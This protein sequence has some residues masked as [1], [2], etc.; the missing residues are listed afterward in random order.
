MIGGGLCWWTSVVGGGNGGG[1]CCGGGCVVRR[2]SAGRSSV[3]TGIALAFS[4][5]ADTPGSGARLLHIVS[6]RTTW[7]R[8]A[9]T[10]SHR[11][12]RP[13]GVNCTL[14]AARGDTPVGVDARPLALAHLLGQRGVVR[15]AAHRTAEQIIE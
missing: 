8:V 15:R 5:L 4:G 7:R 2:G 13:P 12:H 3:Q 11:T 10:A 6:T 9:A 1:C 14:G